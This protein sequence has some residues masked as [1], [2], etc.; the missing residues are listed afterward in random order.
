MNIRSSIYEGGIYDPIFI[1]E[2][3]IKVLVKKEGASRLIN[4]L[5]AP[6]K[7]KIIFDLKS[8]IPLH[9]EAIRSKL[10]CQ[11]L[12][13]KLSIEGERLKIRIGEKHGVKLSSLAVSEGQ[14]TPWTLFRVSELGANYTMLEPLDSAK[15]FKKMNGLKIKFLEEM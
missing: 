1:Q 6:S 8:V 12:M 3:K 7:D 2:D 5:S 14:Y 4:I 11:P 9:V 15:D 13:A 10:K